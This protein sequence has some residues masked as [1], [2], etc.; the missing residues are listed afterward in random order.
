MNVLTKTTPWVVASL[1]A[2]TTIF[3]QDGCMKPK[4]NAH[5]QMMPGYNAPSRID[6]RGSWDLFVEGSFIYWQ[7]SQ[8]N[9]EVAFADNLPNSSYITTPTQVQG[10][11]VAMDFDYLPGFKVGLGMNFDLDNWDSYSEYTRIHG[12]NT[13]STN[14]VE[15]AP[16]L[17]TWGNS[18]IVPANAYNTVSENWG[19]HLDIVDID[20]GRAYYV[21][22]SLTFRPAF[23]ARG[24]WISQKSHVHHVNEDY[25]NAVA[26]I[27][28]PGEL[29]VYNRTRCWSIG[30]KVGLDTKWVVGQ[31]FRFFGNTSA[32]VLY[33]R[34]K[35]QSK[36]NFLATS[37]VG[38]VTPGSVQSVV[39]RNFVI[40]LRPHLD[41]EMGFGWGSYF[42]NNNWHIDLSASYGFQV[43]FD[44]NM[45]PRSDHAF[46]PAKQ[47]LATGN[48]YAQ[49]LT[50]TVRLDF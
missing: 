16:L 35:V 32:D 43:F 44:Q 38:A 11:Y 2:A 31:G 10:N 46:A 49:G 37:T 21:G 24:A 5:N 27:E 9:M 39:T 20:L 48:L 50:A 25:T 29:D 17:P 13:Q 19:C 36:T 6:V 3:G 45:L 12:S 15:G 14:G 41:L 33:T 28:I 18:T 26:P 23:G 1:L 8:D 30:P 40:A 34:Y 7:L 22:N 42:D 47:Q 4:N